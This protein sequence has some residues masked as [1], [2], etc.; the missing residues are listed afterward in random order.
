VDP[1]RWWLVAATVLALSV[2]AAA[3]VDPS[4]ARG[5]D[6]AVVAAGVFCAVALWV[7]GGRLE[8]R[9]RGWR[10]LAL[11]PLFP[12]AGGLAV[13]LVASA[14]P[15]DT[16]V[17]RWLLT[18]PGYVLAVVGALTLVDP[19]RLRGRGARTGAELALFFTAGVVGVQL[20]F[21]GPGGRWQ[22]LAAPERTVLAAAVLV[23]AANMAAGLTVLGAIEGRRQRAALLLF[24]GSVLFAVGRGTATSTMLGGWSG[25][26]ALSR[27]LV[28]AGLA[29]VVL[30]VLVDPGRGEGRAPRT[31]VSTRLG[32]LL[33]HLAMVLATVVAAGEILA[34][35]L[36]SVVT[37]GGVVACVLLAVVHRWLTARGEQL[38]GARL[39]RSEA[40]FRSLVQE[41]GDAVVILDDDLR[42][43][44]SSPALGRVLG[45]AADAL[46]GQ[47]L[48]AAVHPEDAAALAVALP[49]GAEPADEPDEPGDGH[50][51]VLRLPDGDGAWRIFEASISDLRGDPAVA[52]VVLHCRD[53][54]DRYAREQVLHSVAYTDPLTGLPNRAGCTVAVQRAL[55][56]ADGTASVVLLELDGLQAAREDIGLEVVR[57]L[58]AEVGRRLRGTVRAGDLV[59]RLDDGT[60][61]VLAHGDSGD[62]ASDAAQV[63]QLAARCLSVVEHPIMTAAGVVDITGAAG[64]VALEP[65]MTVEDVLVRVELA[66]R[67]AHTKA[68]GTAVRYTRAMGA[69]AARRDRLRSDL[70]GAAVRGELELLLEPIVSLGERRIV[71][72]EALLRWNH[73]EFGD[74]PPAEFLPLARRAGV[75]AE[76]GRW[77]LQ[78]AMLAVAALPEV[79]EP[80][81][82]GVDVSTGWASAG[83]LVADVEAALRMTGLSP[84]RL[85]LEI[86]E[87]TVL[88]DDE[89]IG[90]DLTTLRLMG[91]HVALDGF[92][93]GYS[94]LT[95]LTQLPIDVLKLDRSLVTRIDQDPQGRAL[96]D[97]MIG[98]ARALGVDVVAEGVETPAQLASLSASGYG[99][100]QGRVVARPV[101]PADLAAQ[102]VD[103][104]AIPLPGLVGQR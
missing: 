33:P 81:R 39:R 52:A 25:G 41:S 77:L 15:Q 6:G 74:V 79:A 87:A 101:S 44:W 71:G 29:V 60:F 34:G 76:L 75:A 78:E 82:L 94:G 91:V 2:C 43:S 92:G 80:V 93:T 98:I 67:A 17:L 5:A 102:L 103:A 31:G 66:L 32:Q 8:S 85:I 20:L 11:A 12:A 50:L 9:W 35:H 69:E 86:T 90:L 100:A 68:A 89:R 42:V 3:A 48:L 24:G 22:D 83:T 26:A 96:S 13:A 7:V 99:F 10:L 57:D 65:G 36:P 30:A 72:A 21:V 27:L 37:L 73:P 56:N 64:L 1:R 53:V 51:H 54:T 97:A 38:M 18:V 14:D 4:L 63:D 23:T 62:P 49:R 95:H 55:E 104:A 16:L 40:W 59:A 70:A 19:G 46:T 88:A 84:E 47:P 58:V 45:P 61:A 28:V